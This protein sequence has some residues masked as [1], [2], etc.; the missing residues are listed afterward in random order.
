MKIELSQWAERI[1]EILGNYGVHDS[2]E[3]FEEMVQLTQVNLRCTRCGGI[4]PDSNF[5][6]V[7]CQRARRGRNTICIECW[8]KYRKGE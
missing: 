6:K 8:P 2:H 7:R 3:C 1:E 5:H 4:M